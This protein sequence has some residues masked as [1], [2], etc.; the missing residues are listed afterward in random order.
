MK[1]FN[2]VTAYLILRPGILGRAILIL[3]IFGGCDRSHPG[4]SLADGRMDYDA[5]I[6]LVTDDTFSR[7]VLEQAAPVVVVM[8][9]KWCPECTKA[10]PVLH[11]LS[12]KFKESVRFREVDVESN[13]F[14]SE[15]YDVTQY[16]T[17][18]I[19]VDGEVRERLIGT[20]DISTLEEQLNRILDRPH[21]ASFDS[22]ERESTPLGPS[23][24]VHGQPRRSKNLWQN[25]TNAASGI[26]AAPLHSFAINAH[27]NRGQ[28]FSLAV[29]RR[30]GVGCRNSATRQLGN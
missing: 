28:P 2:E 11:N 4:D 5:G 12:V 9:T 13:R 15:K 8:T 7:E 30:Q 23:C 16:P 22:S 14:L 26:V 3:A 29:E 24:Q 17:L 6:E 21:E 20:R 27:P 19:F 1:Y 18:I 25:P 10:K